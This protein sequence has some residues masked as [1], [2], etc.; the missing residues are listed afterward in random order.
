MIVEDCI[1]QRDVSRNPFFDTML[2][3]HL[4]NNIKDNGN[5]DSALWAEAGITIKPDLSLQEELFQSVLDFK[6]DIEPAG[7]TFDLYLSYNTKL[8][9]EA[10]MSLFLNDFVELLTRDSNRIRKIN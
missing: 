6:L 3:F 10:S 1:K 2:N 8:F 9:T 4:Q 5:S 7:N